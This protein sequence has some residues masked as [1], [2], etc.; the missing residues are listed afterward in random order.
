M[1]NFVALDLLFNFRIKL[2]N[3]FEIQS[4]CSPI[5]LKYLIALNVDILRKEIIISVF[6][7][8]TTRY[9]N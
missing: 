3:I 6:F 5:D 4:L 7:V 8:N 9:F 2:G 1:E